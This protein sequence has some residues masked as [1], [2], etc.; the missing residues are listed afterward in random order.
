MGRIHR[1]RQRNNVMV[2]WEGRS[3]EA[4]PYPDSN[5]P[6]G[7]RSRQGP[8]GFNAIDRPFV[9]VLADRTALIW[10]IELSRKRQLCG[11][12]LRTCF[13]DVS[14]LSCERAARTS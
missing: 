7:K 11:R 14:A 5:A 2:V 10:G 13:R 4:S 1:E 12:R 9:P 6:L 3:C 8:R